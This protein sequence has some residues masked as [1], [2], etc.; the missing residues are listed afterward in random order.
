MKRDMDLVRKLLLKLESLGATLSLPG[1]PVSPTNQYR[2][3]RRGPR[4][5][6]AVHTPSSPEIGD[7][8]FR[9][10]P[11]NVVGCHRVFAVREPHQMVF[12]RLE[13]RDNLC[14][15]FRRLGRGAWRHIAEHRNGLIEQVTIML[16]Q[17]GVD[18]GLLV[19]G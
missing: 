17:G 18:N 4:L 13:P 19:V 10:E 12:K 11:R 2:F 1:G 15:A 6:L 7:A 16:I 8:E 3:I 5:I 9:P 14:P